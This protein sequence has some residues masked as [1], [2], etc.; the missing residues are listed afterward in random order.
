MSDDLIAD[1]L[2]ALCAIDR[3]SASTGEKEAADWVA[4]RL[5]ELGCKV[6]IEEEV[7]YR[8]F[9]GAIAMLCAVAGNA[10]LVSAR[11]RSKWSALAAVIAAAA[12]A[13]DVSNGRQLARRF[14]ARRHPTW[15][16]VARTG[17][18]SA[19]KTVVVLAHHDAPTTGLVF[20]PTLQRAVARR[21][22]DLIARTQASLPMWW[23]V[24]GGPAAVAVGSLIGA[25]VLTRVGATVSIGSSLALA[26]IA[27]RRVTP[28]ANDNASGVAALV[29]LA[30]AFNDRPIEGV[31]VLLVSC[32]SEESLQGGIR[33]FAQRHF[34][35][36]DPWNTWFI[37]LDTVG[38]PHLIMVE[39][40][41]TLRMQDYADPSLRDLVA[42]VASAEGI[43]LIRGL[44]ARI[45]TD[46]VIPSRAG[47]PTVLLA[48][49]DEYKMLSNYHLM[50]D[51]P[52]NADTSTIADAA[53]LTEAVA[54][55]LAATPGE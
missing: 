1:T 43:P 2:H 50:S 36:L 54:R 8:H 23:P 52:E 3:P 49:F 31:R 17:D 25:R 39:G 14:L 40:E 16:V 28:G 34:S 32:G 24:V 6:E 45:S 4:A 9:A 37:N 11:P 20:D 7:A 30:Q 27:R 15:N 41:G 21:F 48:S 51:T 10:G 53:K 19:T 22:P 35:E 5:G 55:R 44:R 13:D 18:P 46:S 47:F 26:D 12:I 42:D 38:S 29:C 33:A